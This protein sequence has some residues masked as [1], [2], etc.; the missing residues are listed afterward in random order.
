MST[1]PLPFT[2]PRRRPPTPGDQRTDLWLSGGLFVA[3][4]VS[5]WLGQIAGYFGEDTP[6][7][8]W[9]LAYAAAVTVPLALRRRYPATVLVIVAIAYFAGVTF[10]I[11]DMYIGQVA[12]F[13]ALYTVGAW[14]DDRRRATIVRVL[15]VIAMFVWL[16]VTTF[17]AAV[18]PSD[19]GLSRAGAFSP[20]AAFMV[21]QFMVNIAYFGGAYYL[22]DHAHAAALARTALE[23]RTAELERERELTTA[24]A[25]ALDRVRIARELHDVVAHH[26]SA[27][28]VQAGAARTVL[29]RNPDAARAALTGVEAS[30]RYALDEM[31]HLL[32]TLRTPDADAPGSSTLHLSALPELIAHANANGLPTTYTVVGEPFEPTEFVQVNLYRI[33]QESLTNARRHGG[34]G[35]TADVRLRYD[36]D[37]IE[38]E[39]ANTGRVRLQHPAGLGL[40]GMRERASA[41]GGTLHVGPRPRGGFLVRVRIPVAVPVP[42]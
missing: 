33:A 9:A 36:H 26:V 39:V 5:S 16:L 20:F 3:A 4:V 19:E 6:G 30:A 15:V 23:E 40:V 37:A 38:L 28:G 24:Q 25:V 1:I 31:R 14:L 27:M 32:E 7:L 8:G 17:Q 2:A 29:E 11:T 12:L 22:G 41:S 10:H 18:D 13:I 35:A 21:I 34:P 42:A